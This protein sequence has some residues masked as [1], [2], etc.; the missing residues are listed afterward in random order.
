MEGV[1][2]WHGPVTKEMECVGSAKLPL[3]G[4]ACPQYA[5]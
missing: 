3:Y 2:C 5:E 1:G 4:D